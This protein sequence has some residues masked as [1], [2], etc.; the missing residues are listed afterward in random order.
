MD[1]AERVVEKVHTL[2]DLEL[3]ALL[4]LASEQ[5]AIIEADA[6]QLDALIQELQLIAGSVFGLSSTV[7]ECSEKTTLDAFG[8]G[9]L[10]EDEDVSYFSSPPSISRETDTF[11]TFRPPHRRSPKSPLEPNRKIANVVIARNL[12]L[13][14]R[15]VQTQALEL[16]RGKRIFTR[17]AV[18]PTPKRFLFIALL[19]SDPDISLTPHLNNQFFISHFHQDEDG[20]PNLQ[21]YRDLDE[22]QISLSSVVRP[23][24]MILGSPK[25]IAKSP[26]FSHDDLEY[27]TKLVGEVR[28][29]SEVFA[30]MH[31]VIAFLR[32]HRAVS[33]GISALA[34]RHFE[35]L[36]R[37][38]APLHGLDYVPPS[39]VALAARKIYPHR[40]LLTAP[41]NDRSMQWGSSLEAVRE[42]LDGVTVDDVIE[43]VLQQVEVPL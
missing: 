15:Q 35:L 26:L 18:H 29:S 2:S 17:T 10:V 30:Y 22:D 39:L 41:E 1:A 21:E 34:T 25:A 28:L 32:L 38:L 31:N 20:L 5:H 11:S 36:V 13:S 9:L 4:C 43:E 6:S 33:G 7:L 27:I 40:I 3:A 14:P 8:N 19:A 42:V 12:N 16:I 37:A 24:S 23:S